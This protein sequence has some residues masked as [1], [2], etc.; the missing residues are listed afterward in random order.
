[1]RIAVFTDT[2][3]SVSETFIARQI[4]GLIELGHD[5][6]IYAGQRPSPAMVTGSPAAQHNLASRTSYIRI[7]RA[8]GYWEMPAFPPWGE[9]WLPGAEK[10]IHNAKRL[11][12]ALPVFIRCLL[13]APAATVRSL[14]P[15]RYGYAA[16]S[17]SSL[18]RLSALLDGNGRYDVAHAH[19]GPVADRYRFVRDLW[20][21]PLV[22]SFHG[23]DVGAWPRRKGHNVYAHLFRTADII[24]ANSDYTRRSLEALGCP[25]SKIRLLHMGLDTSDFAFHERTPPRDAAVE[26]L[27]V[28]RLV[29]K[30]GF[31]YGIEAVAKVRQQ[32]PAITYT[33]VGEGPLQETLWALARQL[34]L[35]GMVNFCGAGSPELVRA[36]MAQAHLFVAPSVTAEDGDMEGQGLV[37]QEAQACGLPVLA[38]DHDG[39]PEGM[40][41]GRSGFLVPERDSHSLVERLLYMIEHPQCW[42]EW[43]RA[44]RQHVEAHYDVRK[45][46]LQLEGIYA[47]ARA[48]YR[49]Q[50]KPK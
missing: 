49:A 5:V 7:P 42:P 37:L 4:D 40:A 13:R 6:H 15:D 43:G 16:A 12:R 27:S 9:T 48:L 39:L 41:A 45:L 3:P 1:M 33:I 17:L 26:I 47:E 20:R 35:E 14:D 44:G 50:E 32:Y 22:A 21:V 29:E 31:A 28:G 38:T 18:Y 25:P 10:P 8:S 23:Y 30:K 36:K 19:F 34:G 46:N 24:T 11:L 2:F